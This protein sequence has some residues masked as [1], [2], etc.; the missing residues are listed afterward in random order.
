MLHELHYPILNVL[1][2]YAQH[3]IDHFRVKAIIPGRY[4]KVQAYITIGAQVIL[5]SLVKHI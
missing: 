1:N 5:E 2:Q 4:A 3:A